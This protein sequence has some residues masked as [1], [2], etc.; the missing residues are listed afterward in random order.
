MPYVSVV[1]TFVGRDQQ[2]SVPDNLETFREI[3]PPLVPA[4]PNPKATV[5]IRLT[6]I[7]T[8]GAA[9][10]SPQRAR[11]TE[12]VVD[13]KVAG[14]QIFEVFDVVDAELQGGP[15]DGGT[16]PALIWSDVIT[17]YEAL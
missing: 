8:G 14:V 17:A 13:R 6:S 2:R 1:G 5:K 4:A 10:R 7:P 11:L 16:Y 3:W 9:Q 15:V 12:W